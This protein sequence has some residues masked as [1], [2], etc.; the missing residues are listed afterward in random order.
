MS[1]MGRRIVVGF[2]VFIMIKPTL[3][4]GGVKKKVAQKVIFVLTRPNP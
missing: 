4:I 1:D 2:G 3:P